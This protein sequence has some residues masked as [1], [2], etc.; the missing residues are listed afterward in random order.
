M[1]IDKAEWL[2][3]SGETRAMMSDID[4]GKLGT[5]N[6]KS[7]WTLSGKTAAQVRTVCTRV[8]AACRDTGSA[9]KEDQQYISAVYRGLIND[10]N[11]SLA[12]QAGT[13]L[14]LKYNTL[15]G[16]DALLQ[17]SFDTSHDVFGSL[18]HN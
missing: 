4:D 15:A 18:R 14:F 6:T 12:T 10:I 2:K 7:S 3:I 11:N 17:R 1:S 13:A 16:C 9:S 5:F 8:E